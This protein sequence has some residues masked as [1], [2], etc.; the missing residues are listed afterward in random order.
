MLIEA[1]KGWVEQ[2]VEV[3]GT[4]PPGNA[5]G[6]TKWQSRK[7]SPLKK[8]IKLTNAKPVNVPIETLIDGVGV[9]LS[10]ILMPH[11]LLSHLLLSPLNHCDQ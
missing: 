1:W 9:S 10:S 4:L 6:E 2:A 5:P 8:E 3:T 11:L 7:A